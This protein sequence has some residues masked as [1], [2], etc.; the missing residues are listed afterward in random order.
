MKRSLLA[1]GVLVA[2]S[3]SPVFADD[4]KKT[5][6]PAKPSLPTG[7]LRTEDWLAYSTGRLAPGEIDRMVS[8]ELKKAGI[9]QAPLV[10]DEGFLRRAYLDLVGRVPTPKEIA[11]FESDAQS[12]KRARL[13]D[14]LLET[15]EYAKHWAAY[16]RESISRRTTDQRAQLFARAFETWLA[17]QFKENRSWGAIVREILTASGQ[18]RFAEPT[19]NGPAYFLASRTGAD[20]PTELAS[21]ASRLFMGIQIQC[22][23]CH[24]HPSDVWKRNQFHEFAAFFARVRQAPIREEMKIVGFQLIAAPFGEH[25][26]P[27]AS[28]AKKQ[29]KRIDP[30][31]LDGKG[32]GSGQTDA[33]R[34][35]YLAA[36]LTSTQAPWFGGAFVNR[37]W[38]ELMGQAFYQPVDDM[39]PE[40]EAVMP[41]VLARIA[42]SFR[43]SEYDVKQ[44]FRDL[45]A[46][47]I[48]Q[49]QIRPGASIDE[50]LMFAASHP[51]RMQADAL[52]ASLTQVLGPISSGRGF[53]GK[54]PAAGGFGR[55]GGGGL[56][57]IFKREFGFDP[58]AKPEDI[59]G[60]ISQALLMMN[61]PQI[62][63]KITAKGDNMLA[64]VLQANAKDEDAIRAVYLRTMA[65]EPSEREMARCKQHIANVTSRPE[66]YEDILWAILNSA[67]FQTKK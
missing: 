56:E 24:D 36:K 40:K 22:A 61:N 32:P 19:K 42:G 45:M 55:F 38:G 49:R 5:P 51:K 48:Y 33:K 6:T 7:Y 28:D 31:F 59:E 14:R 2:L 66:A 57:Q 37:I 43:G 35:E 17:D 50:H 16:W 44:V 11:E 23:Q 54:G 18:L 65:R 52:W 62:A 10:N 13:V 12:D 67:E 29:G 41:T 53:F 15:D 34:R 27:N 20:A 39:G 58:S 25:Q 60:S 4:V 47:E 9:T 21:E 26:M 64:K 30:Q 63:Q 8:A 46:T 1:W 3:A